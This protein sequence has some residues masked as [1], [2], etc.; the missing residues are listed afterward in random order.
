MLREKTIGG[1]PLGMTSQ[2]ALQSSHYP[3]TFL[4]LTK[5]SSRLGKDEQVIRVAI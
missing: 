4:A 1:R 2:E 5:D 3:F